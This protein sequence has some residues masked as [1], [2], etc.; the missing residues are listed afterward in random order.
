MR[1]RLQQTAGIMAYVLFIML[2]VAMVFMPEPQE[3]D[4]IRQQIKEE[5]IIQ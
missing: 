1:D 3:T 4:H 2:Y 5:K